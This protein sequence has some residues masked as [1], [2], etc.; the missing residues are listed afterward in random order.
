MPLRDGTGPFG[1]GAGTGRGRGRCSAGLGGNEFR[2]SI[3]RGKSGWFLGL[4]APVMIAAV[5]DLANPSG[6]LRQLARSLLSDKKNKEPKVLRDAQYSVVEQNLDN[7][8]QVPQNH[9]GISDTSG[10]RYRYTT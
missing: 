7:G 4:A 6:L 5:R 1:S 9:D 8:D 10:T 3:V 2:R